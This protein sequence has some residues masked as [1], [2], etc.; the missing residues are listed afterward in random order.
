D[1]L[2]PVSEMEWEGPVFVGGPEI[3]LHGTAKSIYEQILK[4]NPSYDP[5][6]FPDYLPAPLALRGLETRETGKFN[7]GKGKE[8][9]NYDTQCLEGWSYLRK[10]G[11]RMCGAKKNSCS[12]VSC[13][14]NC[15]VY[16]CSTTGSEKKVK[17][18]SLANDM[19]KISNECGHGW[20]DSVWSVSGRLTFSKHYVQLNSVSC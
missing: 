4:L 20:G 16:L 15:G 8:V 7:C 5:W 2:L 1:D 11:N 17:C 12:R 19:A 10:L 3:T 14:T 6:L 13:S 18:G 9:G